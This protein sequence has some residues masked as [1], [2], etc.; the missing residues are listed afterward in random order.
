MGRSQLQGK[1]PEAVPRFFNAHVTEAAGHLA[2]II[3][4]KGIT[5]ANFTPR[6]GL[7]R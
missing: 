4:S 3:Q 5:E 6:G 7:H 2:E 1:L